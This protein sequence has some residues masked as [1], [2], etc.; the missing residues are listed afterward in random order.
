MA[1]EVSTTALLHYLHEKNPQPHDKALELKEAI[2]GWLAYIP[3]TFPHYTRHTIEHSEEI[4]SQM[5]RLSLLGRSRASRRL[6]RHRSIHF[7][8]SCLSARCWHGCITCR[9]RMIL[10]GPQSGKHGRHRAH[11]AN[12]ASS[13]LRH[14]DPDPSRSMLTLRHFIADRQLRY[15]IAEFIGRSH[16]QRAATVIQQHQAELARFALDDPAL[17]RVIANV[18]IAHGL[19]APELE[20][21]E[22]Y[23]FRTDLRGGTG[24]R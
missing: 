18:C 4:I 19:T 7:G 15:L 2:A 10:A 23:P 21:R 1:V 9:K 14:C 24:E 3:E 17:S 13:P 11:L 6:I 22:L 5:L 8:R 20:D 16:H 12:D